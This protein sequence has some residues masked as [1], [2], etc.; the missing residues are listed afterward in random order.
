[1]EWGARLRFFDFELD[2]ATGELARSGSVQ[3][4]ERQPSLALVTLV[5]NHGRLVTRDALRR[6]IWPDDVHVDFDGSLNYCIR[7][8]RVALGDDPKV[9]RFIQTVPRQGYRFI[10][11]VFHEAALE[12]PSVTVLIPREG[13]RKRRLSLRAQL[14]SSAAAVAVVAGLSLGPDAGPGTRNP[15]HHRAAVTLARVTHDLVFG[16]DRTATPHHLAARQI[17]HAVHDLLF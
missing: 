8:I 5:T 2:P 7:Q 12:R 1:M 15:N 14:L 3:S 10:A 6:A 16:G 17:A 4:L 11:P 9:P 13:R